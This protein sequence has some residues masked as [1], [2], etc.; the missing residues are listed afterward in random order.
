[1]NH[2]FS[3]VISCEKVKNG[4]GGFTDPMHLFIEYSIFYNFWPNFG[5][6]F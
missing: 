5:P 3:I 4:A 1:M 6:R 2:F